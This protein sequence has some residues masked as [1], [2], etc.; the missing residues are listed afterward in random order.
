MSKSK[1]CYNR[2]SVGQ[3]LLA[4]SSRLGPK[5]TFLLLSDSCGFV[6]VGRPL[7]REG[8]SVIYSCYWASPTQSFTGP[9]PT[10]LITIFYCL[11][12]ETP[13]TW[14]AWSPYLYLTGGGPAIP[15]GTEF[16]FRRLLR[17][18]GLRWICESQ[19]QSYLRVAVYRQ[20]VHLV[21]KPREIHDQRFFDWIIAVIV[22]M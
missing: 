11:R 3:S 2:L 17:L 12:F 13:P 15:Q 6:D 22:L 10:G 9:S 5:T 20:S 19:V 16:P 21:V 7:R 18:A 8:V 4:L 14:R 1:L